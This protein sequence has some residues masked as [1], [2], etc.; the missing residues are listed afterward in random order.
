MILDLEFQRLGLAGIRF[1]HGYEDL[2]ATDFLQV[3]LVAFL[4]LDVRRLHLFAALLGIEDWVARAYDIAPLLPEEQD[5]PGTSLGHCFEFAFLIAERLVTGVVW[6]VV[7]VPCQA[8]QIAVV[9]GGGID[10]VQRFPL[11][12]S[13]GQVVVVDPFLAKAHVEDQRRVVAQVVAFV[14][15][16][17]ERRMTEELNT[18]GRDA[19]VGGEFS[20]VCDQVTARLERQAVFFQPS[21]KLFWLG[22]HADA[23]S[24]FEPMACFLAPDDEFRTAFG[25][26]RGFHDHCGRYPQG[27]DFDP[28][29]AFV[30]VCVQELEELGTVFDV[31]FVAVGKGDYVEVV[32]VCVLQF[33]FQTGFQ[34]DF[35]SGAVFGFLQMAIVHEDPLAVLQDDLAG[36]AVADWVEDDAVCHFYSL[37]VRRYL[38]CLSNQSLQWWAGR[39]QRKHA[40]TCTCQQVRAVAPIAPVMARDQVSQQ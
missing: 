14:H 4:R 24:F 11:G 40:V 19:E 2:G 38:S 12:I 26:G 33:L 34:I 5:F 9:L 31:V 16:F 10:V 21:L 32:A 1:F 27:L 23:F 36:I 6:I 29:L 22:K 3:G 15:V 13:H 17:D 25:M 20:S 7:Q 28:T 35:R 39:F 18:V 8:V 37:W 30:F